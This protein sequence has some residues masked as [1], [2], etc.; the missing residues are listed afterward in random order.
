MKG[1]TMNLKMILASAVVALGLAS[2]PA[3]AGVKL[4][5]L[6]CDVEPGVGL[7][8]GSSKDLTCEFYDVNGK[9][10]EYVGNISRLGVDIGY[11][12]ATRIIWGVVSPAWQNARAIEGTYVGASTEATLGVGVGANALIG[13]LRN[14][15][16]LQPVSVQGQA[17]L[18]AALGAASLTLRAVR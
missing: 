17:G 2:M 10:T 9:V 8:I 5:T 11:T 3:N 12:Q 16:A 18:S 1:Y 14:S 13:G 4:G 7:L 15:V 6:T